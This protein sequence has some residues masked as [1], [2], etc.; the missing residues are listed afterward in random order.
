M[1]H[2][3][4]KEKKF[5]ANDLRKLVTTR[6][7]FLRYYFN[8]NVPI[9]VFVLMKRY[10]TS[11]KKLNYIRE[12]MAFNYETIRTN[13]FFETSGR[14]IEKYLKIVSFGE[15]CVDMLLRYKVSGMFEEI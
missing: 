5:S 8:Q 13:F 6:N 15:V 1:L 7:K 9:L 12:C 14:E 11:K 3:L 4:Q 10:L 2:R